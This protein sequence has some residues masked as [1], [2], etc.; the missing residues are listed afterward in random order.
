MVIFKH[1]SDLQ[2]YLKGYGKAGKSIGFV[3]TMGA[4]HQG[5][6]SLIELCKKQADLA[7]VSIFVNPLQF[8]DSNDFKKYPVNPE[9]D[10]E[11]LIESK[12]DI[13][14]LPSNEEIYPSNF[15]NIIFNIGY[16]N[17][18]LEAKFRPGHFNGVYT[19]MK[20]LLDIV[21]PDL[22]FM[23]QKDFQQL[24]VVSK[25]IKDQNYPVELITGP[26]IREESGLAMSSRNQRLSSED[27]QKAA[28]LFEK[29]QFI[30]E[31][32][33]RNSFARLRE[34][35][36][37]NLQEAHFNVEY[38]ALAN[39]HT[40]DLLDDFQTSSPMILLIAAYIGPVRLIDN[41]LV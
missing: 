23:G 28:L 18:I 1:I 16:L 30:K 38:L 25:L 7:V 20:R 8:N 24:M 34:T 35:A 31:N 27:L 6:L 13:L 17:E 2:S 32:T 15:E 22:L 5:H 21:K 11:L 14:F 41:L 36:I 19:V 37:Q 33:T 10:I 29:L 12:T 9:R 3:P 39:A 26:T 4:L 40:L